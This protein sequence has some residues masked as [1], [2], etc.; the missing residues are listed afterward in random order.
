MNKE[1]YSVFI[2]E[3]EM[4]VLRIYRRQKHEREQ[5]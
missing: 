3:A 2:T 4:R 5:V 1:L